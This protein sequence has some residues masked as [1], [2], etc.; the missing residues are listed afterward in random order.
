MPMMIGTTAGQAA[1]VV[2]APVLTRL[3]SPTQFGYLS[4]YSA[5]LGIFGVVASLG[6]ELAIPICM[7]D[8]ATCTH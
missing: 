7:A 8:G 1:S 3:Y 5:V 4:V 6:L 2:L